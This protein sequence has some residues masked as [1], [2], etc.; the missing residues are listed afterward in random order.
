MSQDQIESQQH[1]PGRLPNI[2]SEVFQLYGAKIVMAA[3]A[4]AVIVVVAVLIS[5]AA[6]S[7][8]DE[9][10]WSSFAGAGSAETFGNVAVDHPGSTVAIWARLREGELLLREALG[11]Q[12]TDRAAAKNQLT[13][14]G[15]AFDEVLKNP[16]APVG[17]IEKAM[18]GKARLLEATCTGKTDEAVQA[19]QA[20]TTRFPESLYKSEAESRIEALKKPETAAFYAWF[21]QQNP[22]IDDRTTPRDG[23][24]PGHPELAPITLPPIPEELFPSDWSDLKVNET[25]AP[26]GEKPAEDK[27]AEDK[28]AEA[29]PAAD[30]PASDKPAAGEAKK[31]DAPA[32]PAKAEDK[33]ADGEAAP[34]A[35]A[36][37]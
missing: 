9:A 30:Q 7:G 29:K 36:A 26:T 22:K 4:I 21:S 16:A 13:S 27:P 33:S 28:P 24:P 34:K 35:D 37:K 11:L 31:E 23:L 6:R 18:L 20:L 17:A 10:G 25:A 15:K 5:A 19:W 1:V 8:G 3:G 32:A 2:E 12:F 14:A